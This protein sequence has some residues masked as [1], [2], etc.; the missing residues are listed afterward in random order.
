MRV[1]CQTNG[2]KGHANGSSHSAIVLVAAHIF[3]NTTMQTSRDPLRPST[4]F[5]GRSGYRS[6]LESAPTVPT[7]TFDYRQV[8]KIHAELGKYL[9]L[10]LAGGTHHPSSFSNPNIMG[11]VLAFTLYIQVPPNFR[12]SARSKLSRLAIQ[13]F[14]ELSTDVYDELLRRNEDKSTSCNYT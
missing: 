7:I 5:S 6:G 3:L 2:R 13:H 10:Y 12:S 4:C 8:S 14:H 9:A 1:A 11:V